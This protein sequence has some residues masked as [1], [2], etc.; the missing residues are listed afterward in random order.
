MS[1]VCMLDRDLLHRRGRGRLA[2]APA[3]LSMSTLSLSVVEMTR[4][5]SRVR[6]VYSRS[7][8]FRNLNRTFATTFL[9][10]QSEP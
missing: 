3:S 9:V 10:S 1:R 4:A 5:S 8:A 7:K 2:R 6:S